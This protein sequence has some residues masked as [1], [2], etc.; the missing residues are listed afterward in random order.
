VV[1]TS[2]QVTASIVSSLTENVILVGSLNLVISEFELEAVENL[3]SVAFFG[4]G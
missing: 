4:G 2:F 3:I 1:R